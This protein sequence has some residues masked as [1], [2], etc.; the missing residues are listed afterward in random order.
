MINRTRVTT[1][2][3]KSNEKGIKLERGAGKPRE[4]A[5]WKACPTSCPTLMQ[6]LQIVLTIFLF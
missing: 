3:E 2:D 1:I 5:G 4:P 6:G